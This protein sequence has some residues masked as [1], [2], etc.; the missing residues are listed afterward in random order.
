MRAACGHCFW[1]R[2]RSS[3]FFASACNPCSPAAFSCATRGSSTLR[4][5]SWRPKR[6]SAMP[7]AMRAG[8]CMG[9]YRRAAWASS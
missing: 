7:R 5:A 8:P 2:T 6:D 1:H 4:A 3:S 9:S